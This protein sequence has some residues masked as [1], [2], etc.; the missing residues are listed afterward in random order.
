[1]LLLSK[2]TNNTMNSSTISN[3][4]TS[5]EVIPNT[6]EIKISQPLNKLPDVANLAQLSN[7]SNIPNSS[8][9]LKLYKINLYY[10]NNN[11]NKE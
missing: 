7:I 10:K 5:L 11:S 3:N 2:N 9:A 4:S 1:M 8:I 6:S